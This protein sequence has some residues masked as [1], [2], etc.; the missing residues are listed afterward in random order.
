MNPTPTN[1]SVSGYVY[2]DTN[3]DG[4]RFVDVNGQR[5]AHLG[6]PNV[7]V[8][9]RNVNNVTVATTRTDA[10]GFYRFS[11][12]PAG[13]YTLVEFQP[14]NFIDGKDTQRAHPS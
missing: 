5:L 11:N 14:F 1:N 3:N 9:L 2:V 13:L 12:L 10:A 7:L 4:D 6:I 8:E